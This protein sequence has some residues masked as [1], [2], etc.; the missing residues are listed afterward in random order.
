[1]SIPCSRGQFVMVVLSDLI[2]YSG[3]LGYEFRRGVLNLSSWSNGR[4]LS[5]IKIEDLRLLAR[6]V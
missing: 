1:M 2:E 3:V 6:D 4:K 5:D